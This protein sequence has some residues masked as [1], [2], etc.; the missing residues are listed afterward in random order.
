[1]RSDEEQDFPVRARGQLSFEEIAKHR[2]RSEARRA[3]LSFTLSVRQH[4]AHDRCSAIWNQHF[5]LHA[6]GVDAGNTGNRDT[7]INRV[8][9]NSDTENDSS[10]VGDLWG[11]REATGTE[12][13]VVVTT[14]VPA[15]A[16][17]VCTG[18][19]EPLS[20]CAGRLLIAVTLGVATVFAVPLSSA[21]VIRR[22]I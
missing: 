10:G 14:A 20:I 12:T 15:A 7:C 8:V 9:F 16:C 3:L 11:D 19:C 6:L 5:C 21:A 22:L 1:M 13:K 17:V 4:A 18:I 2:D